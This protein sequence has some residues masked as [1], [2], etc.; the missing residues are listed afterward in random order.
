M[1]TYPE[2]VILE[3]VALI[4]RV[5]MAIWDAQRSRL[6][7]SGINARLTWDC[8]GVPEIFWEGYRRDARVAIAVVAESR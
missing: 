4:E 7:Q 6:D 1:T 3:D 2:T 8:D 5:A